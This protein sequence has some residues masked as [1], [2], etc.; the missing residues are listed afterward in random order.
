PHRAVCD[1]LAGMT[2]RFALEEFRS[3][4]GVAGGEHL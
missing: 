1:Y 2:D 4:H 3:L